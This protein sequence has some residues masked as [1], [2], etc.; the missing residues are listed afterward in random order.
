MKFDSKQLDGSATMLQLTK[1]Q[2]R[3]NSL[4][5]KIKAWIVVQHL[6]MPAVSVLQARDDQDASDKTAEQPPQDLPLYLPSSLPTHVRCE[7]KLQ[8]YEF[9]LREAQ[10]YEVLENVHQHLRL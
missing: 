7:L 1:M 4:L 2:E 9:R 6:Y 10:A 5:R 3:K 8:Q